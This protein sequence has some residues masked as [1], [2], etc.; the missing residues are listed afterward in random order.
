MKTP[1]LLIYAAD[2]VRL[3]GKCEKTCRRL[4][5]KMKVHYG[6]EK[7]QDLTFYQVSEFLKIP[8]DQLFPYIKM[9]PFLFMVSTSTADH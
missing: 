5:L 8:V 1:R 3:S 6:L 2:L 4:L 7:G 9:F